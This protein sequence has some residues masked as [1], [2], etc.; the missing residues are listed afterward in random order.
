VAGEKNTAKLSYT[1]FNLYQLCSNKKNKKT[2]LANAVGKKYVQ[3][4]IPPIFP[5]FSQ[6]GF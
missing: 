4:K 2:T 1:H 3:W 6:I 5:G